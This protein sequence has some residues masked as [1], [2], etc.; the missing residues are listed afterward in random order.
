[1]DSGV[2]GISILREAVK[3]MPNETF[4]YFGDSANAPYGTKP[5][6]QIRQ[7]MD[8]HVRRL[9]EDYHIKGV[10]IACNTATGAAAK[11]LRLKYPDL[12]IVGVEPAL[13]P[14]VLTHRGGRV[15]VMAT[16]LTLKQAK[17]RRLLA[18]YADQAQIDLLPCPGLMEFV[19]QGVLDGPELAQF[20]KDLLQPI[21]DGNIQSVVLGCTHYP[22]IKYAIEQAIGYPVAFADGAE[23]TAKEIKRRLDAYGCAAEPAAKGAV[24]FLNTLNEEM[25]AVSERLF[26]LK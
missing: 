6:E 21:N 23:G 17:F 22:F 11:F 14:A 4:L 2:G 8:A 10:V 16:P 24:S 3:W 7:L 19:E 1:M 13:K 9:R 15:I 12:P 18:S 5:T 26:N 25:V 20:L